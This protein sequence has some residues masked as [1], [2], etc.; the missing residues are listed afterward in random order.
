MAGLGVLAK[1][2]WIVLKSILHKLD[3]Y[4]LTQPAMEERSKSKLHFHLYM[5]CRPFLSCCASAKCCKCNVE[6]D[7]DERPVASSDEETN[8]F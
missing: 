5:F 1:L 2:P 7:W 4:I 3:D 8:D 6:Q